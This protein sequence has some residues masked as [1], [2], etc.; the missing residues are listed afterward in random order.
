MTTAGHQHIRPYPNH[1]GRS[2]ADTIEADR[3][4]MTPLPPIAPVI[5]VR[6]RI[7]LG[8][9]YYVRV[10]SNDYSVDPRFIGRFVDVHADLDHVTITSDGD[11]AG[12]H[13]RCWVSGQTITDKEHV[14]TAQGL[15]SMFQWPRPVVVV[16]DLH[17]DL[18]DYDTAFG[19]QLGEQVS[20]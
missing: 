13:D 2:Y 12:R 14:V 15:R 11:P 10:G 7:R 5:G 18:A 16:D 20:A 8:R 1:H 6:E 17:R 4:A 19:V 9:D 3:A